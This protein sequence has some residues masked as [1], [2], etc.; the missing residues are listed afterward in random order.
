MRESVQ[1][2]HPTS[3]NPEARRCATSSLSVISTSV[4]A[5]AIAS[6]GKGL[7]TFPEGAQGGSSSVSWEERSG[8]R[9]D[10]THKQTALILRTAA[11][12]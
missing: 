12:R 6:T 5:P 8:R 4:E 2:V 7:S 10:D 11:M 9:I 1:E 3:V